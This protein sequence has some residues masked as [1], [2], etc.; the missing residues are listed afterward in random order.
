MLAAAM[1]INILI[2]GGAVKSFGVLFPAFK[3]NL[4]VSSAQVSYIP[5]L[6]YFLYSS[7]GCDSFYFIILLI[8]T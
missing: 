8:C 3:E 4:G 5:A 1:L 2:I 7:L 6:L